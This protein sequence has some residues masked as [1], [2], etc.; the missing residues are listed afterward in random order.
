MQNLGKIFVTG[1]P[2]WLGNRLVNGLV[3]G[4]DDFL[5][6]PRAEK[7]RCLLL[8]GLDTIY[9]KTLPNVEI[10]EGDVTQKGTLAGIT[11]GCDVVIHCAGIIH[12]KR[13]GDFYHINTEG[14]RNILT[15]AIASGTKRFIFVSS[16]S[17]CGTNRSHDRL[18]TEE[19]P[20]RPYK[21]YGQS[22]ML[23]EEIVKKAQAEGKIET[24]IIRPCW[25]YGPGQPPRQSELFRMIKKGKPPL[26][27]DG[28]NL[29]SMSYVDNVVQGLILAATVEH[30]RGQTYWIADE[31]P[32][33]TVEI[34]KTIAELLGVRDLKFLNIPGFMCKLF[35]WADDTLQAVDKYNTKIH[36][37]G[38]MNK[39]IA[40]SIEK[41][42]RE[43]G[44]QPH[45]TLREGMKRS[46]EWCR[47]N[48]QEA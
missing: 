42:K 36:V 44:Y 37:A 26:F 2:G 39:N 11:N 6:L 12:P 31:R 34:Y 1:A 43:L 9:L 30:A 10:V 22:K 19:S 28:R 3:Q 46:I 40:C 14:T 21:N 27:G 23:A 47:A 48:G 4:L 18:F 45:I 24:V 20:Y 16:N 32:Y 8:S 38:E 29:R 35:E 13:V 33:E 17:P 5:Q 25:F 7:V 15:E 41:A